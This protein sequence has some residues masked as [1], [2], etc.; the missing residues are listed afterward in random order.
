MDFFAGI[1][2]QEADH[3]SIKNVNAVVPRPVS[4]Y[5]YDSAAWRESQGISK[6]GLFTACQLQKL[7]AGLDTPDM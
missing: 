3:A 5:G 4:A 6:S 2:V 7:F 1:Q